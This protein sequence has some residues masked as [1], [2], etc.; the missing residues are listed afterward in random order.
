MQNVNPIL[1]VKVQLLWKKAER[2][3]DVVLKEKFV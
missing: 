3:S 2:R 1:R